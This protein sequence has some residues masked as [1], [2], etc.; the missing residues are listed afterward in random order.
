MRPSCWSWCKLLGFG[1]LAA[2]CAADRQNS[3]TS[4]RVW[5]EEPKLTPASRFEPSADER[6][7]ARSAVKEPITDREQPERF[8]VDRLSDAQIVS[9]LDL[10][11]QFE[12]R[13]ARMAL[14]KAVDSR[15]RAYAAKLLSEHVRAEKQLSALGLSESGSLIASEL[16]TNAQA[17]AQ[18]LQTAS[19][20]E[21]DRVYIDSQVT[22]HE[23]ALA[24]LDAELLPAARDPELE[25]VLE[26][27]RS[28]L[29]EHLE[30]ARELQRQLSL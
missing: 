22:G 18:S 26:Q 20:A 28:L 4:L 6:R 11:H 29:S 27:V 9:V 15:V 14:S 1:A 13:Q 23:Q 17:I 3:D 30:R 12:I 2:G 10:M 7:R 16:N 25:T 19:K 24:T 5:R 21:F 8:S